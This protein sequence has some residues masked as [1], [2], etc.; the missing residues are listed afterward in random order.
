MRARLA[1]VLVLASFPLLA[2]AQLAGDPAYGLT[3]DFR[4]WLSANGYSSYDFVRADVPGGS[5]GGRVTPGQAVVNQPVIFI[6]GNSDSALGTV[7]PYTGWTS[8]IQYFKSQG[9]TA[10]ELYATTWGPASTAQASSQYHSK[11]TMLRIRAFVAAVKAYTGASKVDIVGHSMGVTLARKAIEGGTAYDSAAGGTYN[12][13][14]SMTSSVDTFVGISGANR[15]LTS[16]YYSGT[17]IPTCSDVNGFYPG[18]LIGAF[19]P[20]DVSQILVNMNATSHDEG[21]FV[22]TIWSSV[23][24]VIGYGTIVYGV[25]TCRIPGQNGEATF[26]TVPYGHFGSKDL[27]GYYQWRMV[28]YHATS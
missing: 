16:C 5:Y 25:S 6:H 23:D 9:Y 17:L 22:Y 4:N 20:Y 19:G 10:A 7:S 3:T 15:G 1:L 24:E 26:S 11:A 27:T 13:G 14:A 21:S 18:Y 12:L 28:K 2:H 8:S